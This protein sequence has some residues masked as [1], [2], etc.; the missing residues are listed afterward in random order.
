MKSAIKYKILL[1]LLAFITSVGSMKAIEQIPYQWEILALNIY[2]E[3]W[4]HIVDEAD[5]DGVKR[6]VDYSTK[7][8]QN[9]GSDT[10]TALVASSQTLF[11]S[12]NQGE[13]KIVND[14]LVSPALKGEVS[15]YVKRFS[16]MDENAHKV[17]SVRLFP[18]VRNADG[19]YTIE[20]ENEIETNFAEIFTL[21]QGDSEYH[22]LVANLGEE[23]KNVAF[24]FDYVNVANLCAE[25]AMIPDT[26]KVKL[27]YVE[28]SQGYTSPFKA[29]SNGKVTIKCMINVTN[30]GNVIL[31]EDDPQYYGMLALMDDD[32]NYSQFAK[33]KLPTL[34]PGET[35]SSE[36]EF[37]F[38]IPD[39]EADSSGQITVRIDGFSCIDG[40]IEHKQ[41]GRYY[42]TT[43]KVIPYTGI[44]CISYNNKTYNPGTLE[45]PSYIEFG[46]FHGS[47]SCDVILRNDGAAPLVIT[48]IKAPGGVSFDKLTSLPITIEPGNVNQL[49]ETITIN[50]KYLVEGPI[51][52]VFDGKGTNTIYVRGVSVPEE[53]AFYDFEDGKLPDR[54]YAYENNTGKWTIPTSPVVSGDKINKRSLYQNKSDYPSAV[55]TGRIHFKEGEKMHFDVAIPNLNST[56]QIRVSADR[57]EWTDIA[58]LSKDATDE[59]LCMP[60]TTRTW[61]SYALDMPEGDWY[62]E[63]YGGY[64]YIDNI[65]GGK[66][67]PTV[68]DVVPVSMTVGNTA[69]V[70]YPLEVSSIFHNL[71]QNLVDYQINMLVNGQ[72]VA[73]VPGDEFISGSDKTFTVSYY[74]HTP[75]VKNIEVVLVPVEGDTVSS[76]LL[77]CE[78]DVKEETSD[79]DVKVGKSE[80]T[81]D[82]VPLNIYNK[83]S[84]SEYVYTAGK[85]GFGR[86]RIS[87]MAYD[88]YTSGYTDAKITRTRIWMQNTDDAA[89]GDEYAS[90]DNM[91]LVYE[92]GGNPDWKKGGNV[93]DMLRM[94][95]VFNTPFEY[96]GGN[97]RVRIES[98]ADSYCKTIFSCDNS[99]TNI[100][101]SYDDDLDKFIAKNP[102]SARFMPVTY[103][104]TEKD[105]IIVTGIVS[106]VVDGRAEGIQGVEVKAVAKDADVQYVTVTAEDGTYQLPIIQVDREYTIVATHPSYKDADSQNVDFTNPVHN[107][108]LGNMPTGI[109]YIGEKVAENVVYF[110]LHGVKV[111]KPTSGIYV[112]VCNGKAKK[113]IVR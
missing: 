54:W 99:D 95:F 84:C 29:D 74:P 61:K 93:N 58:N 80:V 83:N 11:K 2:P 30:T 110:N 72:V 97:L 5:F 13:Y 62:V 42:A 37:T 12:G 40:T 96:N 8:M 101:Y 43:I 4:T 56:L 79:L 68:V 106:C 82:T 18:A 28:L 57:N 47:K 3:G 16:E 31:N 36:I 19:S 102:E 104:T 32:Q 86:C 63:F 24:R 35:K 48:E 112:R 107:F 22:K 70:N 53:V 50:G 76:E 108:I 1:A 45:K 81:N 17:S 38:E 90:T 64:L 10:F 26:R 21:M 7:T 9:I 73:K 51:T 44:L 27:N 25:G 77:K 87:G 55:I 23:Y 71:G 69:M 103:F 88:F 111:E 6:T 65:Y 14:Y 34:N 41:V 52:L 66:E 49:T 109:E 75:G 89:V 91:V 78:I 60:K 100:L 105:P 59:S 85:L 20:V 92:Y 94:G 15:M 46:S 39:G 67:T 33:G 113:V 98:N